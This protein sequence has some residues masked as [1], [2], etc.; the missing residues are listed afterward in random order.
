M[1][2]FFVFLTKLRQNRSVSPVAKLCNVFNFMFQNFH[3][4][5]HESSKC[6]EGFRKL[7][8]NITNALKAIEVLPQ[9]EQRL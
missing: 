6:F 7:A 3:K 1:Q 9:T 4:T 2:I 5:R 8:W